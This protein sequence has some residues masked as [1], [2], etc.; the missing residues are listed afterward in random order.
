MS[1]RVD[2]RDAEVLYI[3]YIYGASLER[4]GDDA[5]HTSSIVIIHYLMIT[6]ISIG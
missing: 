1:P 5:T 2:I 4:V 3:R 6:W